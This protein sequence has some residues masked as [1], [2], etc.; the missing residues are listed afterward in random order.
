MD[1]FAEH[2]DIKISS[3]FDYLESSMI[4]MEDLK[5]LRLKS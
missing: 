5:E 1:R 4:L 2:T 3:D